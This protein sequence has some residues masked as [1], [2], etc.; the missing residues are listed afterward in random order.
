MAMVRNVYCYN[1]DTIEN[2]IDYT[3]VAVFTLRFTSSRDPK[4]FG[5]SS[6]NKLK[7]GMYTREKNRRKEQ[8]NERVRNR[9]PSNVP[10]IDR[11]KVHRFGLVW[12]DFSSL[13]HFAAVD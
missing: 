12:F 1:T 10:P 9:K 13:F 6:L 8:E 2:T 4:I 11:K 3:E 5:F 7:T